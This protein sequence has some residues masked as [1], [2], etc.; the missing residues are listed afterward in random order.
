[1]AKCYMPSKQTG[2]KKLSYF[3]TAKIHN[4]ITLMAVSLLKNQFIYLAGHMN[5]KK[6]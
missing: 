4:P 3:K 1:M 2:K 5:N 6:S